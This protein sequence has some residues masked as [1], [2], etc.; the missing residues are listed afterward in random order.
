MIFGLLPKPR[1]G[2]VG[3]N[4]ETD[5]FIGE[6]FVFETLGTLMLWGA[7]IFF[8]TLLFNLKLLFFGIL[9]FNLKLLF[10]GMLL[11]NLKLLFGSFPMLKLAL[12]GNSETTF[13]LFLLTC[14]RTGSQ[15]PVT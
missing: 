4:V 8:G 13:P 6:V 15:I 14:K 9:L 7:L 12:F 2:A 1:E 10:F 11:F 3:D 5:I